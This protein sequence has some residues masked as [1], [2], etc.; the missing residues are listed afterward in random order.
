MFKNIWNRIRDLFTIDDT[1]CKVQ[2]EHKSSDVLLTKTYYEI[3][4]ANINSDIKAL[5]NSR[6]DF[7]ENL[8]WN[9]MSRYLN[10]CLEEYDSDISSDNKK[11]PCKLIEQLKSYIDIDDAFIDTMKRRVHAHIEPI[12]LTE[13]FPISRIGK[14]ESPYN[15]LQ[16][17]TMNITDICEIIDERFEYVIGVSRACSI[18][19]SDKPFN[20]DIIYRAGLKLTYDGP[21][22]NGVVDWDI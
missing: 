8:I 14:R 16:C 4:K 2:Y 20:P 17:M 12:L 9:A 22:E 10:E 3:H 7:I 1:D 18:S 5:R 19:K 6:G 21:D 11:C 13:Q 15:A